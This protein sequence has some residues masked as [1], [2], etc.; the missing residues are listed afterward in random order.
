MV[1]PAGHARA[2]SPESLWHQLTSSEH[3]EPDAGCA[4]PSVAPR[5]LSDRDGE[6]KS[7]SM[8]DSLRPQHGDQGNVEAERRKALRLTSLCGP[9]SGFLSTLEIIINAH[10]EVVGPSWDFLNS[11]VA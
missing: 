4:W 3:T 5:V 6:I 1:L 8:A 2:S 11:A 9:C 10:I 7:A